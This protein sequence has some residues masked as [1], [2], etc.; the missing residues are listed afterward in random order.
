M[1]TEIREIYKCEFCRKL[2]QIK[3]ACQKHE[4]NCRKNPLNKQRCLEGCKHLIKK[5]ITFMYD[6]YIGGMEDKREILFC[7]KK[8]EGV[9]P[10]WVNGLEG[11]D[12]VGDIPNNIMPDECEFFEENKYF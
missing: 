9:Y 1:I 8:Q 2:Y 5:E 3:S 12:I 11:E 10:Y 6:T 7:N 4:P